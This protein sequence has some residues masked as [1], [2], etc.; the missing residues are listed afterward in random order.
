KNS[1][2]ENMRQAV[3]KDATNLPQ[4]W[5]TILFVRGMWRSFQAIGKVEGFKFMLKNFLMVDPSVSGGGAQANP[6]DKPVDPRLYPQNQKD[7]NAMHDAELFDNDGQR[8]NFADYFN[9]TKD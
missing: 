2:M 9:M 7:L 8:I 5:G 1:T 6:T 4:H 3:L